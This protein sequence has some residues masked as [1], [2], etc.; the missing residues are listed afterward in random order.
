VD[1]MLIANECLDSQLQSRE[2]GELCKLDLKKAYDHVNW[3]LLLYL[4]Q[5]C[6]LGE[7]WRAWIECCI[8]TTRF[9]IHVNGTPSGFFNSSHG[10]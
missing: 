1:S 8:S 3:E 10:L 6:G 5:G 9:S 4:L 7:K 2:S